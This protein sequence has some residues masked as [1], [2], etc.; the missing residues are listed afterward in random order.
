MRWPG[1]TGTILQPANP[2]LTSGLPGVVQGYRESG[3]RAQAVG[4]A[5]ALCLRLAVA[6]R[7]RNVDNARW[8]S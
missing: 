4:M 6:A 7:Q 5:D 3:W 1:S 2:G 8:Q